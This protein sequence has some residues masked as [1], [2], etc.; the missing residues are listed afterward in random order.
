MYPPD[1]IP[2]TRPNTGQ[3]LNTKNVTGYH[4]CQSSA[5]RITEKYAG[6]SSIHYCIQ[7]VTNVDQL[8]AKDKQT[9][10]FALIYRP[11]DDAASKVTKTNLSMES[12][13][14]VESVKTE[15]TNIDTMDKIDAL[16]NEQLR[17][18]LQDGPYAMSIEW[19]DC[20][21][22]VASSVCEVTCRVQIFVV[23][24][25]NAVHTMASL[26]HTGPN[27]NL[28]RKDSLPSSWRVSMNMIYSALWRT[29]KRQVVSI[30]AILPLFVRTSNPRVHG[31]FG[32][33]KNLAVDVLLG[34]SFIVCGIR[35]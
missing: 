22:E 13:T 18:L 11:L 20:S 28:V 26:V 3:Q 27:Q 17:T 25:S 4:S 5:T 24:S 35:G 12:A 8:E 14:H 9:G 21:H 33:V 32:V 15:R 10:T 1:R 7:D 30:E 2:S 31:W 6:T 19:Y 34:T 16:A 29:A 23:L